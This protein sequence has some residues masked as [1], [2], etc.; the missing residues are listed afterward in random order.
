MVG[1]PGTLV[2]KK[3]VKGR[4]RVL[5]QGRRGRMDGRPFSSRVAFDVHGIDRFEGRSWRIKLFGG[6][7]TRMMLV[8]GSKLDRANDRV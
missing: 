2:E 1:F 8:G 7:S 5:E 4:L 3:K 6:D